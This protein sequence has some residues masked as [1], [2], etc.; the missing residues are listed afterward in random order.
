MIDIFDP[1]Y[2]ITVAFFVIGLQ[3]MSK[4][5]T[6]ASGIVWAG[7]AMTVSIAVTFLLPGLNNMP[8]ILVG[9]AVGS[10]MG[11][12]A[13]RKVAMINM[14]QMVAIYNGMGAGAAAL[15]AAI[16]L[17]SFNGDSLSLSIALV[18]ALIG[19]VSISGSVLAFLK[20]Q[21]WI[22]QR[23]IVFRLQQPINISVILLSIVFGVF[24]LSRPFA[25]PAPALWI[26]LFF[27]LAVAYGILMALPI[28]GADMP[29]VIALLNALTGLAVALDGYSIPNYAMVVAG[30]LVGASGSMLTLAMAKAMNRSLRNVLFGAFGQESHEEGEMKGSLKPIELEDAAILIAYASKVVLIPG[31]GMAAAQAQ[32][33]VKDLIDVLE[34]KGISVS[35]AIHPVAG[36]MPGHMNVLLA[37]AGVPYELMQDLDIANRELESADVAL[38]IGAN[39]VVNPSARKEGS[40]LYGM[41]I[42]N[43]DRAKNVVVLKRGSGRGFAGIENDLF[44]GENAKLLYGDAKSSLEKLVQ[45]IKKL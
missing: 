13:A 16:E 9:V 5:K 12:Y 4:P 40:P 3:R 29:V 28:G 11:W 31:F 33:S 42:L 25:L 6:A 17:L 39:D 44:Y 18:G 23:P 20:L 21:G 27:L 19:S 1:V 24:Y 43:A 37:E 15:I 2:L 7:I 14:P 32:F 22:K 38:V 10:S 8:L 41:P 45:E 36:R 34:D 26:S 30:I 35:C